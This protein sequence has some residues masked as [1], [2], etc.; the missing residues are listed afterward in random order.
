MRDFYLGIIDGD[1]FDD[2]RLGASVIGI[3]VERRKTKS[4]SDLCF[5]G[6]FN[7][8]RKDVTQTSI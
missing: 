3:D 8:D 1:C 6:F 4:G 5:L 2:G 7:H